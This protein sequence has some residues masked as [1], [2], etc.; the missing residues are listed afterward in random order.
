MMVFSGHILGT[1]V[2]QLVSKNDFGTNVYQML[3][4]Y[5]KNVKG[6][7]KGDSGYLRII[8]VDK[9]SKSISVKTYSLCLENFRTEPDHEFT[10]NNVEF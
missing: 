2:G 8:K 5:Q 4:N 3:A 9:K 10:F 6:V 7:E 1:G